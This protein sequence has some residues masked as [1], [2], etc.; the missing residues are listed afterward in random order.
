MT[1]LD[2]VVVKEDRDWKNRC[3]IV[4]V[5]FVGVL[6][7]YIMYDDDERI[8]IYI[9]KVYIYIYTLY[10]YVYT[11]YILINDTGI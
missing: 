8:D 2:E 9:Y 5:F 11:L 6:Y 1:R 10:I 7:I 3:M 4:F